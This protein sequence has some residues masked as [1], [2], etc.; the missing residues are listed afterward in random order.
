MKTFLFACVLLMQP[1]FA[2]CLNNEPSNP[3]RYPSIGINISHTDLGIEGNFL[4]QYN[5]VFTNGRITNQLLNVDIRVPLNGCLTFNFNVGYCKNFEAVDLLN[6]N[7]NATGFNCGIG[8][9]YYMKE[10]K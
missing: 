9:R 3:D 6:I 4:R 1:C 7:T 10:G 8:I 5:T 2:L